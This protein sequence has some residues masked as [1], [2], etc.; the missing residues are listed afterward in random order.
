MKKLLITMAV[1]LLAVLAA[2]GLFTPDGFPPTAD[3]LEPGQTAE[4]GG[5]TYAAENRLF[6]SYLYGM[7]ET[8]A[9]VSLHREAGRWPRTPWRVKVRHPRKHRA[10][11][12]L[13]GTLGAA[14]RLMRACRPVRVSRAACAPGLSRA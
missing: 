5:L 8:G 4:A 9:V 6:Q 3:S 12:L 13:K 1:V 10:K 11:R 14:A 2:I 7:D